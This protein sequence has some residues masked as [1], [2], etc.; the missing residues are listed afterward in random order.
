MDIIINRV[1]IWQPQLADGM[2]TRRHPIGTKYRT[3]DSEIIQESTAP[4][5]RFAKNYT[6][7]G[8]KFCLF[9]RTMVNE[10]AKV[11]KD[12]NKI[13]KKIDADYVRRIKV[14][15]AADPMDFEYTDYYV[16]EDAK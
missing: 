1:A 4:L 3:K 12:L 15:T 10:S 16:L 9:V 6:V 2:T 5:F 8:E 11:E 14:V 13:A 7:D